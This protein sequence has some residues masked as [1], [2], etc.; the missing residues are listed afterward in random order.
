MAKIND[1]KEA[2]D[3]FMRA[4]TYPAEDGFI[5]KQLAQHPVHPR[6]DR[7]NAAAY[8]GF[9]GLKTLEVHVS[10]LPAERSTTLHRHS[11][12][13][14]FYILKGKGYT[15]IHEDGRPK[16]RI[17]WMEGDLFFTPILAWH[18]HVNVSARSAARY[19][20]VTTIPLMKSLGA[21]FIE[22]KLPEESNKRHGKSARG[23][24]K[25]SP[26]KR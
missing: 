5:V 25:Q 26:I 11:C 21:W 20:E 9:P 13:A 4:F 19:L 7:G 14:L 15:V 6:S 22:S 1:D 3:A 12:E 17:E 10:E 24:H 2:L 23:R 8:F 16:R 18:Q